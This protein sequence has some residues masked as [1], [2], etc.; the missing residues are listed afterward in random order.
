MLLKVILIILEV[1][2]CTMQ[3]ENLLEKQHT[4]KLV[5]R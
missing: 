3:M 5:D 1:K 2:G 4:P